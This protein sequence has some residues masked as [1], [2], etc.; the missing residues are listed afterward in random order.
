VSKPPLGGQRRMR[1]FEPAAGLLR[2]PI[3]LAG[4]TRGFAI[5]RLLT[6]WAEIVGEDVARMARPVKMG[7]GRDGLGATLT[8]L[9][10]GAMAPLLQMEKPTIRAKVNAC[11]GYNAVA[12]IHITQTA[13]IGFAEGQAVFATAPKAPK[14]P[15]PEVCARA[16]NLSQAVSDESLRAALEALGQNILSRSDR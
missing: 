16:R 12:R 8:L 14:P 6:Q 11:Y 2:E 10:T 13:P 9:T 15:N 4:E 5:T 7:Y 3:R 1:G